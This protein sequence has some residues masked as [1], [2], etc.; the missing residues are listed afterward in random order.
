M[1][2]VSPTHTHTCTNTYTH[3]YTYTYHTHTNIHTHNT[4]THTQ[5]V[6]FV[7]FGI[8]AVGY[9]WGQAHAGASSPHSATTS[10]EQRH[11]PAS[12]QDSKKTRSLHS[13]IWVYCDTW[14]IPE[15]GLVSRLGKYWHIQTCTR[16]LY[17]T[18]T[19]STHT[20]GSIS[21]HFVY[22]RQALLVDLAHAHIYRPVQE[23]YT[24]HLRSTSIF[25]S[26]WTHWVYLR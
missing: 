5:L 7:A 14:C 9:C 8:P 20:F 11:I 12:K 24:T 21:T 19:P 1:I 10:H 16:H 17:K 26:I 15:I 4:H 13:H 18:P 6:P 3:T 2:F 22:L 25:R 23:T